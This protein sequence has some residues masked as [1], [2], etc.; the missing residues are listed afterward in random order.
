LIGL[1]NLKY[2]PKPEERQRVSHIQ[3]SFKVERSTRGR[4][5]LGA[6]QPAKPTKPPTV[7]HIT[8]Q[9]ALAIR[10]EHLLASG[11]VK[12]QAEFART[13]GITRARVTQIL[14][15]NQLAPDIQEAILYLEPTAHR[16]TRVREPE[17]REIAAEPNWRKQRQAWKRLLR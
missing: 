8:K 7:P 17:L 4:Y 14:N 12:D 6:P 1:P 11:Q 9:M 3:V 5:R 2:Q 16:A 15:L 10:L 13:A